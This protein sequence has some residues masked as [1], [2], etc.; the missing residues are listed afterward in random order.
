MING[1][2]RG[3]REG[4]GRGVLTEIERL[5]APD[6]GFVGHR[7]IVTRSLARY[8]AVLD[9]TAGALLDVGCGR[10][11]GFD[12]LGQRSSSQTGVDVSLPFLG[13]AQRAYSNASF[14]QAS[15]E[16]L[17]FRS[18]SFDTVIAF[19]VI[20]HL[21]D[22]RGFLEELRRLLRP[23]GTA[24]ISTPNRLVA[25]GQRERPLN[26]FHVREYLVDEF[27]ALLGGVFSQVL[28]L[29][30]HD[31]QPAMARPASLVDRIPVAW[32][33][34]LPSHFQGI[35]S[36]LV[37]PALRIEDCL[38]ITDNNYEQAHTFLAICRV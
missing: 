33:Y 1:T 15:G 27:A 25:S 5:E 7:D 20:E 9:Y 23:G 2:S 19:E 6:R 21:H 26:P 8:N 13:A 3:V 35:A 18:G 12:L 4:V 29:G 24:A 11:Y 30:Q 22:D 14:A 10:G 28:L 36:V 38:F 16:R 17:P 31:G 34:L 37:R 32:K